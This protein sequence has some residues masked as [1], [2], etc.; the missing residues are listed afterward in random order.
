MTNLPSSSETAEILPREPKT[1][2]QQS[3]SDVN[4]LF[5]FPFDDSIPVIAKAKIDTETNTLNVILEN[6]NLVSVGQSNTLQQ[7]HNCDHCP[8]K[9]EILL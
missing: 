4:A 9:S 6:W 8:R 3:C 7:Q 2:G 5:A 1:E